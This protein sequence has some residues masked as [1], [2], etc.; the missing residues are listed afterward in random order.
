M[1]LQRKAEETLMLA[2]DL[3]VDD[4]RQQRAVNAEL[5]EQVEQLQ[6]LCHELHEANNELSR[7]LVT[8]QMQARIALANA[9]VPVKEPIN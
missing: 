5:A 2:L 6:K 3:A 7:A 4:A 9:Q 1:D 8:A